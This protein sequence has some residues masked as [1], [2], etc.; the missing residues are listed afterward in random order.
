MYVPGAPAM[1]AP[2]EGRPRSALEANVPSRTV[3]VK[4][5]QLTK[6]LTTSAAA[7]AAA[8]RPRG[9]NFPEYG[10]RKL[11]EEGITRRGGTFYC[12]TPLGKRYVI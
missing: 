10:I 11:R 4:A 1:S 2:L 5:V 12:R 8:V 7:R 3:A 9:S 6:L